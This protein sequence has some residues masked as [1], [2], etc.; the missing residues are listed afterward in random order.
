[1]LARIVDLEYASRP[2]PEI[3]AFRTP[4][5]AK[6]KRLILRGRHENKEKSSS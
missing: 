6:A 5:P 1:M 3:V 2:F 4:S